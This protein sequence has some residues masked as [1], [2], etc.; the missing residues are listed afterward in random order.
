M[1]LRDLKEIQERFP[2][3]ELNEK[4]MKIFD[5]IKNTDSNISIIGEAGSGKSVLLSVLNYA[6]NKNNVVI[7]ASTGVASALL[8]SSC[9][10]VCCTTL[11]STFKI[12]PLT[13]YSTPEY[14]P[15]EV[16]N[17][18]ENMDVLM[19]DECS[20]INASLFDYLINLLLR[21]R[22][23]LPRIILFSDVMQLPPVIPNDPKIKEYFKTIYRGSVY[24]FNSNSYKDR[25]FVTIFLD[26]I[27]RQKDGQF[28]D[29]LN[30]IRIGEVTSEDL[31][32]INERVKKGDDEIYWFVD[33]EESLRICTTNK[34]VDYFN[35][36][37]MSTL[38]GK[39]YKF[40]AKMSENFI[41]TDKYKSGLFPESID[42][43]IGCP[44]MITRNDPMGL[45]V[46]G[47][48]GV[49][50]KCDLENR[51][52]EV[53]LNSGNIVIV[54]TFV[55]EEFEYTVEYEK[56]QSKKSAKV[57][58]Q[59]IAR[60]ENIA[61]RVCSALTVHKSQGLTLSCGYFDK[62]NWIAPSGVYVA[63]SRFRNL[64]DFALAKP[65][66]KKDIVVNVEA[67]EF[68]ESFSKKVED[69]EIKNNN[70][71]EE[72]DF[73]LNNINKIDSLNKD[74]IENIFSLL[75]DINLII[76]EV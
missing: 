43:K 41:K 44:V 38:E 32:I 8:N 62:G 33:H 45:F 23:D 74:K 30:R 64:E 4:Y 40:K 76:K 69:T 24:F 31:K 25:N 10:E 28:K 27:Y 1:Y 34:E 17:L 5:L 70:I 16:R 66:T 49:I 39:V 67:L 72:I 11:H 53:K 6:L 73:L 54:P 19:I 3:V 13:I 58:A 26:K 68:I 55:T 20:M 29:I 15:S 59:P 71:L 36:L 22:G 48:M 75:K 56:D 63:L 7:C 65:L 47:D 9:P 35:N 57:K 46:N 52:V 2:N 21:V 14:I 42:L 18:I 50:T 12:P 60:Y 51:T 37:T 61:I